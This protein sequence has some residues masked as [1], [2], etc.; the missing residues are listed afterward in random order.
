[1]VVTEVLS[2]SLGGVFLANF[3][4]HF[5]AGVSGRAFPTPFARPPFR[6]QS[7]PPINVLWALFNLVAAYVLLVRLGHFDAAQSVHFAAM[8]AGF[9]L[10]SLGIARSAGHL[11]A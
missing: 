9:G 4:P 8:L 1:M 3:A 6:G 2:L 11:R 5:V 7:S 10:A